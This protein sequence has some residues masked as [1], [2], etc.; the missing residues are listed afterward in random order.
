MARPP[1][2]AAAVVSI[3]PADPFAVEVM[4]AFLEWTRLNR[5]ERT[6]EWY[7]ENIQRFVDR[8]PPTLTVGQLKPYHVTDAMAAFPNWGN[9]TKDDFISA[10]KRA[11]NWAMEEERIE[12]NPL[13][14]L[15][16]PPRKAGEMAVSP[17]QYATLSPP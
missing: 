7:R 6:Y 4:D 11:L 15:K 13:A 16:K 9:N 1:E 3:A 10:V 12:R 17:D 8:I 14:K 5:A 2:Q